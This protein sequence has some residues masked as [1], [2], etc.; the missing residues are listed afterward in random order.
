MWLFGDCL[1]TAGLDQRQSMVLE[2]Y[3]RKAG[4]R[5]EGRDWPWPCGES[6]EG[7]EKEG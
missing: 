3:C 2:L 6:G 7:K 1:S 5:R 4:R